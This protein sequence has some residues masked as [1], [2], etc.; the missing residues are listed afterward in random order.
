[1]MASLKEIDAVRYGHEQFYC[2]HEYFLKR[3]AYIYNRFESIPALGLVLRKLHNNFPLYFQLFSIYFSFL[4]LLLNDSFLT[5]F[6]DIFNIILN[7]LT[8]ILLF[9]LNLSVKNYRSFGIT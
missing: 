7:R 5:V 2:I 3:F 9:N 1:M 6:N 4:F 8:P